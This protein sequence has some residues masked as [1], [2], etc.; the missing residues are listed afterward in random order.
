M[1]QLRCRIL[2]KLG[3]YTIVKQTLQRLSNFQFC[4]KYDDTVTDG[5]GVVVC[6]APKMS[7]NGFQSG[8]MRLDRLHWR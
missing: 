5:E 7:A 4:I 6:S 3:K 8:L 2:F 1:R